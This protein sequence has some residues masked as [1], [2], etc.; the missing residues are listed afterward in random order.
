MKKKGVDALV[1]DFIDRGGAYLG[2]SAGSVVMAKDIGYIARMDDASAAPELKDF[3]GIGY[4]DF[5]VLPH[6]RSA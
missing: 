5:C 3:R 2:S 4:V 6:C 1:R